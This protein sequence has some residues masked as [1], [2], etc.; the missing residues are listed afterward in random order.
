MMKEIKK[1][2]QKAIKDNNKIGFGRG[3]YEL[4]DQIVAKPFSSKWRALHEYE[5]GMFAYNNGIQV[6]RM[7][8]LI[9]PDRWLKRLNSDYHLK[10]WYVVMQKIEGATIR[11]LTNEFEAQEARR[12]L[13]Q[14]IDRLLDL[15]IYPYD[16]L[17]S[18][19]SLFNRKENRLYLLDF[20][21]WKRIPEC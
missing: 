13:N 12:Q 14:E 20:C 4:S 1:Q 17:F 10:E 9:R 11:E 3:V 16:S 6:P 5:I 8:Q 19:N 2:I 15:R 7:H 21:E 18:N